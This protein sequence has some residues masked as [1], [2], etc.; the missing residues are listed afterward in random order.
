MCEKLQLYLILVLS[1]SL[2]FHFVSFVICCSR[3]CALFIYLP[4]LYLSIKKVV[5]F[6]CFIPFVVFFAFFN[7][8]FLLYSFLL[9]YYFVSF[10]CYCC[11]CSGRLYSSCI[12]RLWIESKIRISCACIWIILDS[13]S[14]YVI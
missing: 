12:I 2:F 3:W 6:Q 8:F 1:L 13:I 10:Q 4:F 11:C 14:L 7:V 5:P 9:F